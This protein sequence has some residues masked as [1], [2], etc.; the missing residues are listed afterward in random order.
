M[1]FL[2]SVGVVL[3]M[4]PT[5]RALVGTPVIKNLPSSLP[6]SGKTCQ[7]PRVTGTYVHAQDREVGQQS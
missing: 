1:K 4:S 3:P 5:K 6:V 2:S 7:P